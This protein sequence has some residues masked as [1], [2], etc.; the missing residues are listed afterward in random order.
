MPP[1]GATR[2]KRH[3]WLDWRSS[4]RTSRSAPS[5][6]SSPAS[7]YPPSK[8][9]DRELVRLAV[10]ARLGRNSA[11]VPESEWWLQLIDTAS[12]ARRTRPSAVEPSRA[13]TADACILM[14]S[15]L[16]ARV[17]LTDGRLDDAVAWAR[18]VPA[19]WPAAHAS[20][21]LALA[22]VAVQRDDPD[23]AQLTHDALTEAAGLGLRPFATEAL[24]LLA[25]QWADGVEPPGG[26]PTP[27][28]GRRRPSRDGPALALP[29]PPGRR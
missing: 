26:R 24:E 15:D 12:D 22:W 21:S 10:G 11:T 3:G 2:P 9:G 19:S 28:R 23:A 6:R 16:V 8:A 20:A 5:S 13:V 17:L 4:T 25:S 29:V 18:Q 1:C 27:R 14:A 7:C